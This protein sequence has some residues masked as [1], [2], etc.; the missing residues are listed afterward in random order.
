[1]KLY[2]KIL[3]HIYTGLRE[4]GLVAGYNTFVK[5]CRNHWLGRGLH[6]I[7]R[8]AIIASLIVLV[9]KIDP[10]NLRSFEG[11]FSAALVAGLDKFLNEMKAWLRNLSDEYKNS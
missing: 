10:S 8:T 2:Q 4:I 3:G 5:W 6:R 11:A 1:M 9:A 7:V